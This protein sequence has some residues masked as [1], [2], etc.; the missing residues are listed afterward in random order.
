MEYPKSGLDDQNVF[1]LVKKKKA[2]LITRDHYFM[3]SLRFSHEKT[4][5]II[6]IRK[7]NLS[8]AEEIDLN[9]WFFDD[10]YNKKRSISTFVLKFF[11]IKFIKRDKF[12]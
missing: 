5:C 6:Y 8:S 12:Y 11:S 9:K 3:N 2:V 7:G 1:D 4:A 10:F